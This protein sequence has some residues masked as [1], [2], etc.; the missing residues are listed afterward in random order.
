MHKKLAQERLE[1]L[2]QQQ[3]ARKLQ[4]ETVAALI[5]ELTKSNATKDATIT[6]LQARQQ[7]IEEEQKD[8][9]KEALIEHK[10]LVKKRKVS[11]NNLGLLILELQEKIDPTANGYDANLDY[12]ADE[13]DPMTKGLQDE[14]EDAAPTVLRQSL[15]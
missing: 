3:I 13:E 2:E 6:S 15:L 10:A 12:N 14:Q 8:E 5:V 4:K 1:A 7:E 9:K 11:L